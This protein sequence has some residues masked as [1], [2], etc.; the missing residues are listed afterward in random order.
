M[1]FSLDI[2]M[3]SLSPYTGFLPGLISNTGK[4]ELAQSGISQILSKM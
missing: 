4:I 3:L 1:P 2:L